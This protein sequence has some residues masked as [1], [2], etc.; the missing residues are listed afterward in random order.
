MIKLPSG[1]DINNLI[2]DLRRFSW[3]AAETLLFYSKILR[4]SDYKSNI[5]KNGNIEDPVTSADLKVNEIIIQ[6]INE[7]Y[8]DI[9]WDILSEENVKGVTQNFTSNSDW[10]W[11]LDP[12]DGTKDF[13]Q[14]TSNYAMHLALN[15]KKKPFLGIVLIPEKDELWISNGENV[16]CENRC[17][18]IIGKPALYKIKSLNEMTLV[19]SKNHRNEI[20]KN[21]IKKINFNEV[22][23]MGSIGCKIASIVRGESDIYICLSLPGKSSP[24]DWDFAA[25]AA[26][27]KGAGGAITNLDNQE[28]LYFKPSFEQGGVIVASNNYS[29]HHKICFEIKQIIKKYNLYPLTA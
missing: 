11:V 6:R 21:L 9:D 13:I 4:D 12:L 10:V 3:E 5:L 20:L 15:Y 19:T 28:L 25:P 26:I 16:W 23:I 29:T 1:I 2:D 8:K 18:S 27:L 22:I 24:K 17:G 7:K 14:G